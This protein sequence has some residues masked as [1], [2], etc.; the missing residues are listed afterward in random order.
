LGTEVLERRSRFRLDHK[1][2]HCTRNQ[3]VGRLGRGTIPRPQAARSVDRTCLCCQSRL[4]ASRFRAT[5]ARPSS[6][7]IR[8]EGRPPACPLLAFCCHA[9]DVGN[10]R[11]AVQRTAAP[12]SR[13]QLRTVAQGRIKQRV[14][15]DCLSDVHPRH[16]AHA[17]KHPPAWPG[18]IRQQDIRSNC[19]PEMRFAGRENVCWRSLC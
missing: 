14:Y 15:S 16:F 4:R 8:Q 17:S 1:I 2:G 10:C 13:Q 5:A 3:W 18:P 7:G 11:M 9:G 19:L 6:L 12:R